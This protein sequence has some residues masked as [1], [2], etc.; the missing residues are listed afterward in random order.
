MI[1]VAAGN[2]VLIGG[3]GADTLYGGTGND[4]IFGDGGKV[5]WSGNTVIIESIDLQ[6]GGDDYLVGGGGRNIMIGGYGSDS[7]IGNFN[8]D[9]MIGEFAYITVVNG[10]TTE[11][12]CF[13]FGDDPLANPLSS[14]YSAQG[15][16][17]GE[18][19]TQSSTSPIRLIAGVTGTGAGT[20]TGTGSSTNTFST[21]LNGGTS[22]QDLQGQ[23]QQQSSHPGSTGFTPSPGSRLDRPGAAI[24]PAG[25]TIDLAGGPGDRSGP[26][27]LP[28]TATSKAINRPRETARGRRKQMCR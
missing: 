9:I 7:F 24:N 23:Q 28:E 21:P 11:V 8:S 3:A 10:V 16:E 19:G 13:W 14:L 18:S 4:I 6:D 27:A 5:T 26:A 1:R 15:N 17:S 25:R 20:F 22:N 12:S 2:N